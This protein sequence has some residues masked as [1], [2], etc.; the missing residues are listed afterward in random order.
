MFP[1]NP[2]SNSAELILISTELNQRPATQSMFLLQHARSR[3][4]PTPFLTILLLRGSL[5]SLT[6]LMSNSRTCLLSCGRAMILWLAET[7]ILQHHIKFTLSQEQILFIL[8]LK[9]PVAP[10]TF[11]LLCVT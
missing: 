10:L 11:T 9:S 3:S 5:A 8:L 6:P 1:V 4:L 2:L 7:L